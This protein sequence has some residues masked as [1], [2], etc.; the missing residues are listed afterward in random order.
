[1]NEFA[2]LVSKVMKLKPTGTKSYHKK[3][4]TL[5]DKYSRYF[6]GKTYKEIRKKYRYHLK[7]S[8]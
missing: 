5:Y 1:M 4:A 3:A 2:K 8:V 6:S 7:K